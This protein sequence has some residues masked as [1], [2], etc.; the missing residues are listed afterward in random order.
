MGSPTRCYLLRLLRLSNQDL[1]TRRDIEVPRYDPTGQIG[2]IAAA[3]V[4]SLQ[5]LV[6][7][8]ALEYPL[9]AEPAVGAAAAAAV[10]APLVAED[11]LF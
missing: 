9:A 8:R 6:Q 7:E 1:G 11:Y 3:A 4:L 2:Q 5:G 10:A